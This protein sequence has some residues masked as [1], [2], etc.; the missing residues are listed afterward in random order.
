MHYQCSHEKNPFLNSETKRWCC[1]NSDC[2]DK[3]EWG[4]CPENKA[5]LKSGCDK[6]GYSSPDSGQNCYRH[7]TDEVFIF[8]I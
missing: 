6:E 5:P 4:F 8:L 7:F 2:D 3:L 1:T